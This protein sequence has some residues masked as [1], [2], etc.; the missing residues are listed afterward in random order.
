MSARK[1]PVSLFSKQIKYF[2]DTFTLMMLLLIIKIITSR[3][4]LTD[5]SVKTAT[6][7]PVSEE[8]LKTNKILIGYFDLTNIPTCLHTNF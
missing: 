8:T 1:V 6:L 4:D 3:G 7:V 2:W 5:I